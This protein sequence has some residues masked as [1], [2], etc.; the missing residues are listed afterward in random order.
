MQ[1][2]CYTPVESWL[3]Y[4]WYC[5]WRNWNSSLM[6]S[7]ESEV[8]NFSG[9]ADWDAAWKRIKRLRIFKTLGMQTYRCQQIWNETFDYVCECYLGWGTCKVIL[10]PKSPQVDSFLNPWGYPWVLCICRYT[11]LFKKQLMFEN[12][13][14]ESDF[15]R[16]HLHQ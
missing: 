4:L 13:E 12:D 1:F 7:Q 3:T 14:T 8:V 11:L 10:H 16:Q 2:E 6:R 15:F 5:A 9:C